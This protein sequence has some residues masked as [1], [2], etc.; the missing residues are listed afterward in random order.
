M[1][2]NSE[3]VNI[4][5]QKDSNALDGYGLTDFTFMKG[6]THSNSD[7]IKHFNYHSMRVLNSMD[8]NNLT[9][10]PIEHPVNKIVTN[11]IRNG[12]DEI[13]DLNENNDE[14]IK[15]LKGSP[16]FLVDVDRYIY[17]S[18][19]SYGENVSLTDSF[20]I[21]NYNIQLNRL[22]N[23]KLDLKNV[24]NSV[25]ALSI[26]NELSPGSTLMNGSSV[27]SFQ[28]EIPMSKKEEMK[29][30]YSSLCELLRHFWACFPLTTPKLE[31]KLEL[32]KNSL[33]GFQQNK[34]LPFRD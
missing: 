18:M 22:K 7:L 13:R 21:S 8:E 24:T 25:S 10:Q 2:H 19:K 20:D 16:L 17:G 3:N 9:S 23:W 11:A 32:M 27:E 31:A 29:I 26:L 12:D 5:N 33:E 15:K 28:D 1:D 4:G 34:I 6:S 14:N 30:L